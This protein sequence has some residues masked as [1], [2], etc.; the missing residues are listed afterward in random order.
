MYHVLHGVCTSMPIEPLINRHDEQVKLQAAWGKAQ[1]GSP[2][3]V[4]LSGRRR[5]GKTFLL[6]HFAQPYRR[7]VHT[8]A[9]DSSQAQELSRLTASVA[10][11]LGQPALASF[12]G[13]F[14]SW[15][16]A[17]GFFAQASTEDP[18][19]VVLD[20]LPYALA[21]SP[22]LPS[23][24]QIAWD[25]LVTT[26]HHKLMLVLTGSAVGVMNELVGPGSPL[27]GRATQN[28]KMAPVN[29]RAAAEFLP[30]LDP[31]S[32]I[33]A[34]A[35][36]GGYPLHLKH[37]DPTIT[38]D[39]NLRQLAFSPG[40]LL[41]EDAPSVIA[42]ELPSTGGYR[43]VLNAVGMGHTRYDKI[44]NAADQRIEGPLRLLESTGLIERETPLGAP[45]RSRPLYRITDTYL[46]FWHAVLSPSYGLISGGQ[47][48]AVLRRSSPAWTTHVASVFEEECRRHAI[49]LVTMKVMAQDM[50]IGRWW[51]QGGQPCEV[52]VMGMVDS[53]V[54]LV[55]EAKWT[56][57]PIGDKE[58]SHLKAKLPLLPGKP[59]DPLLA[60]WGSSG[61]HDS[62]RPQ[63][64]MSFDAGDV[65]TGQ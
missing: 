6:H 28:L 47:G 61:V 24:I 58:L 64:V 34:Y 48:E 31:I 12:G 59:T 15:E 19:L 53:T 65:V 27:L 56:K 23:L 60:L 2:Q 35:A 4:V 38:T 51:S 17:L 1:A 37:W 50:V 7:V 16:H 36:C 9:K 10:E 30:T 41:L 33:E 57:H 18:L 44:K 55:G 14:Q 42:E 13:M 26:H 21:A 22:E 3:L 63:G 29:L 54:A 52:D 43:R 49:G 39:E 46:R 5:V 20:E 40:G 32:L 45:R 8:M 11:T 25:R 62:V